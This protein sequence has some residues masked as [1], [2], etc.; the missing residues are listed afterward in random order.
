MQTIAANFLPLPVGFS[1]VGIR[2]R[3]GG[4]EP[5]ANSVITDDGE[6][7]REGVRQYRD[8]PNSFSQVACISAWRC[9]GDA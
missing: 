6:T 2:Q 8:R 1:C 7:A 9:L 4:V 5:T 3:Q